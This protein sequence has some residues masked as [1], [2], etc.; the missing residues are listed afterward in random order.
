M[1]AIPGIG[2]KSREK[3]FIHFRSMDGI[4]AASAEEL[5]K[6]VGR[7]RARLIREYFNP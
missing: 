5:E 1:D 3:L 2:E 6:V 7:K 4:R